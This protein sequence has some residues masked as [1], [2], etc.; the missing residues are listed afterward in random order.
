MSRIFFMVLPLPMSFCLLL[1]SIEVRFS[2]KPPQSFPFRS[3]HARSKGLCAVL[4]FPIFDFSAAAVLR[5]RSLSA[6]IHVKTPAKTA[7]SK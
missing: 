2:I 4:P 1:S 5:K 3:G 6:G 7:H